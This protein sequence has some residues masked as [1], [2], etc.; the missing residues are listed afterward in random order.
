MV[1]WPVS[2]KKARKGKSESLSC[3]SHFLIYL[4]L[5]I[6]NKPRVPYLGSCCWSVSKLCPTLWDSH[7]R[8]QARLLCPPLSPRVCLN[9]CSLSWWCYLTISSSAIL[10]PLAFNLSQ[11]QSFPMSWLFASSGQGIEPSASVLSMKYSGLISFRI[12][13]F[14]LLAI[15]GTL[16]SLL[17][18]HNSKTSILGCS[19]FFMV[20]LSH[21]YVTTRKIIALTIWTFRDSVPWTIIIKKTTC[22]DIQKV[23]SDYT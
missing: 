16:K 13:L 12:D 4:E 23:P 2:G 10:F 9:S 14:D 15:Q 1:L 5:K 11:H 21:S 18:Q 20:Q 19:A 3:I 6:V 8:Q 22:S 7:G 17:Q